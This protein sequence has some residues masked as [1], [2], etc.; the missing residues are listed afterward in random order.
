MNTAKEL[1][2]GNLVNFEGDVISVNSGDIHY[3]DENLDS[4]E[5]I[6]LVPEILRDKLSIKSKHFQDNFFIETNP[7]GVLIGCRPHG[8]KYMRSIKY[9]HQLQNLYFIL[10]GEELPIEL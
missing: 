3:F 10:T 9:L 1:R 7:T 5:G 2:I 6:P 4:F 8:V